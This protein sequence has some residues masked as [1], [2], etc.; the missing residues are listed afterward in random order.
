MI[1]RQSQINAGP[2]SVPPAR[3][4]PESVGQVEDRRMPNV[5]KAEADRMHGLPIRRA[6]VMVP[7]S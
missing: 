6:V 2:P 7:A 4:P 3:H 1:I 5:L